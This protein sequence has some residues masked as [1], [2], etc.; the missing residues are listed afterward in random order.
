MFV[1]LLNS[2]L[3]SPHLL[4]GSASLGIY[5]GHCRWET[6]RDRAEKEVP[7][8]KEKPSWEVPTQNQTPRVPKRKPTVSD[9]LTGETHRACVAELP[10]YLWLDGRMDDHMTTCT[11]RAT[12][13]KC[14][15]LFS[16]NTLRPVSSHFGPLC[17]GLWPTLAF[18]SLLQSNFGACRGHRG[19]GQFTVSS[20]PLIEDEISFANDSAFVYFVL[21]FRL[22]HHQHS[23]N[24]KNK[25]T[26]SIS[27]SFK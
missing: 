18:I 26:F 19:W 8:T 25:K 20:V 3:N 9:P 23:H 15:I 4:K 11:Q 13:H 24:K 12:S 10:W 1:L 17:S 27:G 6:I 16:N 14:S 21:F 22:A 5:C 7:A 2:A